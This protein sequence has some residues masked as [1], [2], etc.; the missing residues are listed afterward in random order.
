[1]RKLIRVISYKSRKSYIL[2][3]HELNRKEYILLGSNPNAVTLTT[4]TKRT[5]HYLLQNFRNL[6]M[7]VTVKRSDM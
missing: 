2:Y 3:F 1:M 4:T 5:L 6:K 7:E